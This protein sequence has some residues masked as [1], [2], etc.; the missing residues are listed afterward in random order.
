MRPQELIP[1]RHSGYRRF[2]AHSLRQYRAATRV[3]AECAEHLTDEQPF[4]RRYRES[5][6]DGEEYHVAASAI[7]D[8]AHRHR[9]FA[10]Y[11]RNPLI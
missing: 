5:A 9:K 10:S 7:L 2:D 8:T 6:P 4:R 3:C 11:K 1:S